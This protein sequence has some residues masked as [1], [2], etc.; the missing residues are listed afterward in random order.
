[1]TPSQARAF[2]AVATQGSFTAAAR[3]L[4]VSQPTVTSQVGDIEKKYNVELFHRTGRGARLTAAGAV[5]LPVVRRMFASFDEA[6]TCLEDF[7]EMRQGHLRIGAYGASDVAALVTRHKKRFPALSISVDIANSSTLAEKLLKYELDVA[8]LDQME[9]HPEFDVLPFSKPVLVVIAPRTEPWLRRRSISIEELKK[10][11]LVCREP[12]SAT[13][14]AFDRAVGLQQMTAHRLLEFGS[15]EGVISA[16]AQRAGLGAIFDEGAL[17]D[18][19]VIKLS[20]NGVNISSKVDL[21]WLGQRRTS[22]L[23]SDFLDVA[24]EYL[25]QQRPRQGVQDSCLRRR[26]SSPAPTR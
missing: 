2:L 1:M 6:L 22:P 13:R 9:A 25:E 8:L 10:Q 19:R 3:R 18:N 24:R 20:I 4:A 21:V 14:A 15:R 23:I 17:A 26:N 11:V 5:L 12:G 16:V 7:R